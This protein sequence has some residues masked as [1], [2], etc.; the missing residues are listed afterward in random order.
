MRKNNHSRSRSVMAGLMG[1]S[2]LI[3]LSNPITAAASETLLSRYNSNLSI[4]KASSLHVNPDSAVTIGAPKFM[5][6][7]SSMDPA[8]TTPELTLFALDSFGTPITVRRLT[9]GAGLGCSATRIIRTTDGGYA[10]IGHCTYPFYSPADIGSVVFKVDA[11]LNPLWSTTLDQNPDVATYFM[12]NDLKE[13]ADGSL[14]IVSTISSPDAGQF[15]NYN[16]AVTRL[17]PNGTLLWSNRY[18][19]KNVRAEGMA[20]LESTD[21]ELYVA[22]SIQ[23]VGGLK[24]AMVMKLDSVGT[25]LW[26]YGYGIN[27]TTDGVAYGIVQRTST[28]AT[29]EF[30]VA[31]YINAPVLARGKDIHVIAINENG[32][33]LSSHAHGTPGNE[34]AR[35]VAI[36]PKTSGALDS[37]FFTGNTSGVGAGLDDAFMME[38]LGPNLVQD[39]TAHGGTGAD[40]GREIDVV[41]G[42]IYAVGDFL[43][44]WPFGNSARKGLLLVDD[45]GPPQTHGRCGLT[46]V[47]DVKPVDI[48]VNVAKFL[49][50]ALPMIQR[51]VPAMS[52]TTGTT[53]AICGVLPN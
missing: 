21:K 18:A 53:N 43:L 48:S 46:F 8:Q 50:S 17:K 28:S 49:T 1:L 6:W 5:V 11:N 12:A 38:T 19:I 29:E 51:A 15:S 7:G 22:G 31:G 35:W 24:Q 10:M 42:K 23:P 16:I 2:G 45:V 20:I 44:R 26:S 4:T 33:L 14:G 32:N 41:K 34:E 3:A 40:G 25:K 36:Q 39:F 30:Y 52:L 27:A 13:L 37:L 47:P 9:N